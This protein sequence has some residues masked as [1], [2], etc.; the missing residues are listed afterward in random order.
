MSYIFNPHAYDS[1]H[2]AG[3]YYAGPNN[4]GNSGQ[5][6]SIYHVI[7]GLEIYF[8]CFLYAYTET[9]TPEWA[10][11][12]VYGRADPIYTYK[13][14]TRQINLT[15]RL[16]SATEGEAYENLAKVQK[17]AQFCYPAYTEANSATTIGQS[18]LVRLKMMNLI[19]NNTEQIQDNS[20]AQ[21]LFSS[22]P[23]STG[24]TAKDSGILGA[25]TSMT[26]NQNIDNFE[27]GMHEIQGGDGSGAT[28]YSRMIDVTIAFSP[29]HESTLGWT[30]GPS[31]DFYSPA[32]PYN[33][34]MVGDVVGAPSE[35]DEIEDDNSAAE[36]S[37][38]AATNETLNG[39]GTTVADGP[40][41][42]SGL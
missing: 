3:E 42:S 35:P 1:T 11:E 5:T 22:H 29:I 10:S 24:A 12:T 17:L 30:E 40:T 28:I 19:Q 23:S 8:M 2:Y 6:V 31:P 15:W 26:I 39:L 9:F 4:L 18:P 21:S 7:S 36:D 25:I 14:T 41:Y 33:A 27:I 13:N 38:L 37:R 20:S 16:P 34:R 32:F